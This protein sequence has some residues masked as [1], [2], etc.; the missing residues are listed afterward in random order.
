[1]NRNQIVL[2]VVPFLLIFGYQNCQKSSFDPAAT[3]LVSPSESVSTQEAQNIVLAH[4]SLQAIEFKSS[5]VSN[6]AHGSTTISVVKNLLY[7]FDL[8]TGEFHVIDQS[9]QTDFKYCLPEGLKAHVNS[10][11]SSSTVCKAGSKVTEGVVCAQAMQSGYANIITNRDSF[12][13]GSATDS[14]GS[15]AVDLCEG[16]DQLK[17]WFNSVKVGL[18]GLGCVN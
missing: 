4:E 13:L 8:A 6:V 16:S 2:I 11:L 5:E 15:N 14:C 10:L 9:A 18:A 1:M 12:H 3:P 17:N 7:H